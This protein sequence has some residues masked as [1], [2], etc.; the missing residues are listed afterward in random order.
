MTDHPG[1]LYLGREYDLHTRSVTSTPVLLSTRT[2]TT[3]AVCLGMTGTGKT[4]LGITV[5]EEALLQGIPCIIID[6]KGDIANLALTFPRLAPDDFRPWLDADEAARQG[7]SLEQLASE[8]AQKWRAGLQE[9]GIGTERVARLAERTCIDIYTPGSDA[10][11]PVNVLHSLAPPAEASATWE[12]SAEVLRERI[13]Q[14]VQALLSLAGIAADP[15]TSREHILLATIF[16]AAWRAGQELSLPLLIRS[17]QEPPV[18]RIGAFDMEAFYP[19]SE[20]FALAMALNNLVASP[21]FAAWTAGSALDIGALIKP[22]FQSGLLRTRAAIFYLAHLGETER[23]FFVTLLLSQLVLWMRAQSGTSVLRCLVYF[24]EVSGYAPPFPRNPPTKSPLMTLIK[25]GRAAGLGIFLATQNPADLDY[26]S[27]S[28]VG[29]WF[30]GRLRTSRDRERALEGLEGAGIGFVR[31]QFEAPLSTLPPRVFLLHSAQGDPH[32]FHSRW[33]MSFLRGPLTREQVAML[34][35]DE[36]EP[37]PRPANRSAHLL[38][39]R[40]E[41]PPG[42]PEVFL[43]VPLSRLRTNSAPATAHRTP[44]ASKYYIPYLLAVCSLRIA[45][46]ASGNFYQER[47]CYLLALDQPTAL[48][49]DFSRAQ[50]LSHFSLEDLDNTPVDHARFDPLPSGINTRWLKQ[51]ERAFVDYVYHYEIKTIW[52]N[53][54]LKLYGQIGESRLA[55]RQR[56][57]ALA[58]QRRDAEA[59]KLHD[60]FDRRMKALQ[61]KIAREYRELAADR[62]ELSSRK[63]EELLGN[64]EALFNLLVGRRPSYAI[65][66]GAR[67]RREVETAAQD[68]RESEAAIAKLNADLEALAEEYKT[69]L[70][71]LNE[72]WARVPN[73]VT[74]VPIT[75][76]K[77]D[78]FVERLAIAWVPLE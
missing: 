33:A 70:S 54:A 58:R 78:I 50:R 64:V 68:V 74:E 39:T 37:T 35:P 76:K 15:L 21:S 65:A 18:Q 71:Q 1:K 9:W 73:D 67:R 7:Q 49:P 13:A 53:R 77:S 19:R 43:R 25:Q 11:I 44:S 30:I 34:E 17:I 75:P 27:L 32:F 4:G 62:A 26:K 14:V 51:A 28:N 42:V 46:R 3:H 38:V 31:A 45:D 69:A 20:R 57:E 5:L 56:C 2:L 22:K 66:F 48:T 6:P 55:F 29:T 41:L 47:C 61:D 40:P 63:R 12:K 16:E 36:A 52:F 59:A 60:Q 23:Q 10:G 72:K 24:D 8:T